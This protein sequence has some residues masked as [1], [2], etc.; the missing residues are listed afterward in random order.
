MKSDGTNTL[1][2]CKC[3]L[4]SKLAIMAIFSVLSKN[5]NRVNIPFPSKANFTQTIIIIDLTLITVRNEVAKVIFSQACVCPQGGVLPQCMMGCQSPR[6]DT[7]PLGPDP[8]G[9][10]TPLGSDTPQE[11]TPPPPR[12]RP[13]RSRYPPGADPPERRLLLPT[14][15]ILLEC[16]LV[17]IYIGSKATLLLL[18][19]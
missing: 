1:E 16:I 19:S 4:N 8:L 10:D 11:Q 7:P 3:F 6:P 14:V 15:H 13:H 5:S 12:S 9:P 18:G 2:N 17:Y